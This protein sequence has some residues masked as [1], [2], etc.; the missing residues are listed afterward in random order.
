M[1]TNKYRQLEFSK[2]TLAA[3]DTLLP[4]KKFCKCEM[5]ILEKFKHFHKCSKIDKES[6]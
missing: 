1:Q 6:N 3:V 2:E 5:N 4:I